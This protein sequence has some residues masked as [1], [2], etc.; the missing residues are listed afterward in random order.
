MA[1]GDVS[2]LASMELRHIEL[3]LRTIR[4]SLGEEEESKRLARKLEDMEDN[5]KDMAEVLKDKDYQALA[6]EIDDMIGNLEDLKKLVKDLKQG[7]RGGP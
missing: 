1:N 3:A 7:R 5:V 4:T 2:K 6:D